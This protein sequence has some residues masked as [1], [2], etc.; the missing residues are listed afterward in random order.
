[1]VDRRPVPGGHWNDTYPFVRLHYPA[2][3]YGVSSRSLG[4]GRIE[5]SGLNKG[6]FDLASGVEITNYYHQLHGLVFDY[7]GFPDDS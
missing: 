5:T 7:S 6:F 2:S 4:N 1:M 3:F